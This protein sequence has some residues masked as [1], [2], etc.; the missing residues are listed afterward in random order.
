EQE[1]KR[2]Q[3]EEQRVLDA[4]RI[5]ILS[6]KQLG[7][8]LEK[9]KSRRAALDLERAEVEKQATASP[10]KRVTAVRD[11]CAEAAKNLAE[12]TN[13]RW[14]EFLRVIVHTVTFYGNSI[15]ILGRIP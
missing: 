6:P 12:F 5:G 1:S 4:Y 2:L 13:G 15:R 14:S 10:E 7:E 3:A 9:L 8:Q 11:Y